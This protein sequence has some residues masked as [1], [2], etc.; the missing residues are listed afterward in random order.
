MG[1]NSSKKQTQ[2]DRD[3]SSK[4][5]RDSNIYKK[6]TLGQNQQQNQTKKQPLPEVWNN[7][8]PLET[9]YPLK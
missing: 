1:C 6:P 5:I 8:Q 2:K 7:P 3:N 9:P 4:G